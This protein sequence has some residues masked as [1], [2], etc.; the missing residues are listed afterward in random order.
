M[1]LRCLLLLALLTSLML[2][3]SCGDKTISLTV[4]ESYV[5][6]RSDFAEKAPV[7]RAIALRESLGESG[8][9]VKLATDYLNERKGQV[10][11]EKEILFGHTERPETLELE[12]AHELGR[13]DYL[14]KIVGQK[15][16]VLAGSDYAYGEAADYLIR[17]YDPATSSFTIP[18]KGY[19]GLWEPAMKGFTIA[20]TPIEEFTIVA[21]DVLGWNLGEKASALS[22]EL[23]ALTGALLPVVSDEAAPAEREIH[24][25]S[26]ATVRELPF[27]TASSRYGVYDGDFYIFAPTKAE[28]ETVYSA[29]HAL[30]FAEGA[31]KEITDAINNEQIFSFTEKL[32]S[33]KPGVGTLDKA[34]EEAADLIADATAEAPVSV[35]LELADGVYTINENV[36]VTGFD[37]TVARMTVRA[38]DGAKPVIT[39]TTALDPSAFKKVEGKDYYVYQFAK[40]EDGNFPVF[41]DFYEDGK[42]VPVA[43]GK[44]YKTKTNFD[45][46]NDRTDKNNYKGLYVT[47]ESVEALGEIAWPTEITIYIEWECATLHAVGVDYSDT[48]NVDGVDLVRLKIDEKEMADFVPKSH[49]NLSLANRNY[50]FSNHTALLAPDSFVY[51]SKTGTL[52]Y[53]P[54]DGAPKAPAY[55]DQEQLIV[56]RHMDNVTF[57]GITFTGTGCTRPAIDGYMAGQANGEKRYGVLQ[58]AALLLDNCTNIAV[59]DCEFVELGGNGIQSVNVLNG[60]TIRDCNFDDISMCAISLGNHNTNWTETDSN[61]KFV[62]DNNTIHDIGMEFPTSPAV[63]V[64]HIDDIKLI[65]NTI[66]NT[67][68]SGVSI[69]WG[70]SMVSY[71]YAEKI[72]I[73]HAEL[74]YNR[75]EDYMVLLR[76]GA[77]IYVLGA[78][79]HV[80]CTD[81]F[82]YM[83]DNYARRKLDTTFFNPGYYLDGSSSNWHVH[84]NVMSGSPQ[85]VYTQFNVESQ[86][87]HN[88][89]TEEIYTT[90]PISS[91]NHAKDR[92]VILGK[93]FTEANLEDLFQA[94]PKAK[95]IVDASG[96][97]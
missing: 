8:L 38:A 68:Y 23:E 85:P 78:N 29:A 6:T 92:N 16:V 48:K 62:I 51:D 84:T 95:E 24:I 22:T 73:R 49:V 69:G 83:H 71:Q 19:F 61:Y 77:A 46:F 64:S 72:N 54:A 39:G 14:V 90:D 94:H 53:Y 13:F 57:K 1:K 66:K 70:W 87:N 41:H 89:L 96:A 12:A 97:K 59:L 9:A 3:G 43:S 25:T 33:V 65:H 80:D 18:E 26:A 47:R 75:I 93:C 5:I 34:M 63:Y 91:K 15:L 27:D 21:D 55:S 30:C 11:P 44:I 79:A 81:L 56:L 52:Y 88:V 37:T 32:I 2:L 45:N 7:K 86:H 17:V 40:D 35:I 4:D 20:G 42:R 82:N 67:A 36:T 28:M 76:D 31:S 58:T 10:A 60:I 50:Y 74:A